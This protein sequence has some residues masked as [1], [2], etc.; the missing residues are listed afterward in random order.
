MDRTEEIEKW[1]D[2]DVDAQTVCEFLEA[3]IF[4]DELSPRAIRML[5]AMMNIDAETTNH[6]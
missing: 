5:E 2:G 4:F 3:H 1:Y 6:K